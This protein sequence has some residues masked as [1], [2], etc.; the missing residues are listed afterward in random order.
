MMPI[1]YL[2]VFYGSI[3]TPS[4]SDFICQRASVKYMEIH[5]RNGVGKHMPVKSSKE[6][7]APAGDEAKTGVLSEKISDVCGKCFITYSVGNES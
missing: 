3:N 7:G 2:N 4:W 5:F 6:N 1:K